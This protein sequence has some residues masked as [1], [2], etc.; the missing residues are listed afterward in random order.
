MSKSG[1]SPGPSA[2]RKRDPIEAHLTA[3][4]AIN[5]AS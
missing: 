1:R 2:T 5:S 4:E 3:L